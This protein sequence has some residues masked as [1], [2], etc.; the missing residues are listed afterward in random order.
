MLANLVALRPDAE[1]TE[2]WDPDRDGAEVDIAQLGDGSIDLDDAKFMCGDVLSDTE[3]LNPKMFTVR[4][5]EVD[6]PYIHGILRGWFFF[7]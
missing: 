7:E 1:S 5:R 6:E 2:L 4:G 3:K